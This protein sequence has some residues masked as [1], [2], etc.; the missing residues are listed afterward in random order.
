[1]LKNGAANAALLSF[2]NKF[3][4]ERRMAQSEIE[5]KVEKITSNTYNEIP[6]EP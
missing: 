1:M 6:L 3:E 5:G 4:F 2:P